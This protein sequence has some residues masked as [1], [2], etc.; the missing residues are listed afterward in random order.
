MQTAFHSA[1]INQNSTRSRQAGC[2]L[3]PDGVL[4]KPF[5]YRPERVLRVR[6]FRSI[7]NVDKVQSDVRSPHDN[8]KKPSCIA[9][10]FTV[11]IICRRTQ[12]RAPETHVLDECNMYARNV[13]DKIAPPIIA[14][15]VSAGWSPNNSPFGMTVPIMPTPTADTNPYIN[16]GA[17]PLSGPINY[18]TAQIHQPPCPTCG[19]AVP[20]RRCIVPNLEL[21]LGTQYILR[22]RSRRR[23]RWQPGRCRGQLGAHSGERATYYYLHYAFIRLQCAGVG[24]MR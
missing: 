10:K 6:S 5:T 21:L 13:H 17:S 24:S 16:L 15:N 8:N 19:H 12:K 23:R 18:I 22:A 4:R 3:I 11:C 9:A 14:M 7:C 2:G 20:P 1:L